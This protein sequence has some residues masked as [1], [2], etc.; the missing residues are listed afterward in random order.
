[1]ATKP[2]PVTETAPLFCARCSA[3]LQPGSGE[4]FR[5]SIEAVADPSPPNLTAGEEPEDV[6][7]EIE[8]LITRLGDTSPQEAMDQ[9]HRRLTLHLCATC[10][11]VWIE[12][13]TG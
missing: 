6:R 2:K 4:F 3:E 9:V 5:V 11:R 1:M 8:R 13:P 7:G 10:F 12:N